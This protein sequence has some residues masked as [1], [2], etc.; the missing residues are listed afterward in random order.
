MQNEFPTSDSLIESIYRVAL[1]PGSYDSFMLEWDGYISQRLEALDALRE[2]NPTLQAPE[3]EKHFELASQLIER[4]PQSVPGPEKA[5]AQSSAP[6][7]LVDASASVVWRNAAAETAL[8]LNRRDNVGKLPL[9]DHQA[10]ALRALV[11]DLASD[12]AETRPPLL[13]QI[14]PDPESRPIHLR[15]ELFRDPGGSD[16]IL[17]AGLEPVW[18]PLAGEMLAESYGLSASE[19]E[20][21]GLVADGLSPAVVA[22]RRGAS[23]ATVRTQLKK[24]M[25]KTGTKS[26][27]ELTA[28]LANVRRL[29]ER[30]NRK[31]EE[32][33]GPEGR[34]VTA[35]IGPRRLD[36]ELHGPETG[37]PVIFLHGM[38]DGTALTRTSQEILTEHNL[39]FICP[40]RPSFG[41]SDPDPG[42]YADA[43]QR[44][45]ADLKQLC[46]QLGV[47]N[48]VLIGHMAGSVYAF[49]AAAVCAPRAIVSVAGGVPITSRQQIS[50][51]TRR[52]RLV[53]FTALHAPT[54]LPY[55]LRAGIHQLKNGGDKRF[56]ASLYENAPVDFAV[57]QNPEIRRLILD[58]YQFS[59]RQGHYAFEIDSHQVVRDWSH[60]VDASE[61]PVK[62]FHGAHDTVVT[63]GSV[64][65]FAERLGSRAELTVLDDAGQLLFYQE[66]RVVLRELRAIFD[67][68]Q[69]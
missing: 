34:I 60:L 16:V 48:P 46:S 44:F 43:P 13:L 42:D 5:I 26:Q 65:A 56:M 12:L 8:G 50:A 47:D 62:L 28:L 31:R 51:M 36:V 40:H 22:K 61:V 41:H 11:S 64:R 57:T 4:A 10:A 68:P 32:T 37:D 21:A 24:I 39:R 66:P 38:L 19:C 69:A 54:M 59:V 49:A 58:G 52:Q 30:H 33:L 53:A 6:Q 63:V 23:V 35:R 3:Y 9:P 55:V 17:V 18:P 1:E 29:A 20:V 27:V 45:A 2:A 67:Q 15:A 25:G 14:Q 7:F